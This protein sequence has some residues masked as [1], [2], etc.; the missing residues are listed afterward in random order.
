MPSPASVLFMISAFWILWGFGFE[1]VWQRFTL[2]VEGTVISSRDVPSKSSGRY[3]TEYVIRGP[4]GGDQ[5]YVAG[6]TDG[7]LERN[8]PVGTRIRKERGQLGYQANGERID[9]PTVF[10][11]ALFGIALGCF[12]GAAMRW[13]SNDDTTL[14][15][16]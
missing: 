10:Y 7:S 15:G 16:I 14:K 4:D 9:F 6:P 8:M 11:S 5:R 1:T 12:V 2:A 3:V 13:R